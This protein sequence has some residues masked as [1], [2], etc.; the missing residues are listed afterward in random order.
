MGIKIFT[1][2]KGDVDTEQTNA[3]VEPLKC[4]LEN[5]EQVSTILKARS[6]WK[7][8]AFQRKADYTD[9]Y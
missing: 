1:Y 3:W 8:S 2:W 5:T 9:Y 7:S 4:A 6:Y